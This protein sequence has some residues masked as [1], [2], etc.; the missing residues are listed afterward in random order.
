MRTETLPKILTDLHKAIRAGDLT[1]ALP[2]A[3]QAEEEW[4]SITDTIST[5]QEDTESIS[6]RL[7]A[8]EEGVW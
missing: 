1:A 6:S 2:L 8:L 3:V 7:G 4:L 5:L